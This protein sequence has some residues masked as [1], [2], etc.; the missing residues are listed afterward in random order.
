MY[1]LIIFKYCNFP[2]KDMDIADLQ[3]DIILSSLFSISNK[4]IKTVNRYPVTRLKKE[5]IQSISHYSIKKSRKSSHMLFKYPNPDSSISPQ[6]QRK[7]KFIYFILICLI[8]KCDGLT[9][10]VDHSGYHTN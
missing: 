1:F 7:R 4:M 8:S 6:R 2:R 10:N 9:L 3:I 5:S